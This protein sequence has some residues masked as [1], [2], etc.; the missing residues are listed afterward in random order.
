MFSMQMF[1]IW[2]ETQLMFWRPNSF[3]ASSSWIFFITGGATT[4]PV[5]QTR[6]YCLSLIV[7]WDRRQGFSHKWMTLATHTEVNYLLEIFLSA[8]KNIYFYGWMNLAHK[9]L[10]I[11][12]DSFDYNT[13]YCTLCF[14]KQNNV[15]WS[16]RKPLN[17]NFQFDAVRYMLISAP[18]LFTCFSLRVEREWPF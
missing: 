7:H 14:S 16:L 2:T 9:L 5:T 8:T 10:I 17:F 15:Y 11:C 18:V 6:V 3:P 12:T 13:D 1:C 4:L